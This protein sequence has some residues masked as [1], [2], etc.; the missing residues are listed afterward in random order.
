MTLRLDLVRT[1][2]VLIATVAALIVL[3]FVAQLLKH[4]K[5]LPSMTRF[6]DSDVKLN[7]P[8][9]FKELA[10]VV[11][12]LGVWLIA[13]AARADGDRW[14]T[15]WLVL[16]VVVA[17]L[18]L[19]EMTY[20]HQSVSSVLEGHFTFGGPLYFAW[21]IVYLPLALAACIVLARFWWSLPPGLRWSFACAAVLFGG[22]SGGVELVKSSI[23]SDEGVR[24][25]HFY[26]AAAA[27]DS[28]EMVGLTVLL[29]TVLGELA[30]RVGEVTL[31]IQRAPV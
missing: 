31:A 27:S 1:R 4:A 25:L 12:A 7:F 2:R 23:A 6:F 28:L 21:V 11:S 22:G 30:R 20:G 8:S 16:A 17:L 3:T 29:L 15:H 26:L 13:R 19:D 24:S 10:L 18:T 9:V 14:A 5:L